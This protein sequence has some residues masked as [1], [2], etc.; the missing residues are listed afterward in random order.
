VSDQAVADGHAAVQMRKERV[1]TT[2]LIEVLALLIFL[3]MAFAFVLKEEGDRAN[4]WKEKH[5]RIMAQL[6]VAQKQ[7]AGLRKE[8]RALEIKVDGLEESLRRFI[9]AGRSP[10]ANDQVVLSKREFDRLAA[11]LANAEAIVVEQSKAND[12]LRGRIKG[13]VGLAA[14]TVTAGSLMRVRL[15]PD[16]NFRAEP[17]WAAGAADRARRIP[18]VAQLTSGQTLTAGQFRAHAAQVMQWGKSQSPKCMFRVRAI[19]GHNDAQRFNLQVKVLE[20]AFYVY[21]E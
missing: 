10:T 4:P 3:A 17:A 21:R 20:G 2:M 13:G 14:C 18:G 19:R 1:H 6:Q 5:D 15:L 16:G 12:D 11:A 9:S 8:V 7:V